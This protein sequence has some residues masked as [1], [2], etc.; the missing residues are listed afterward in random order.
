[1]IARRTTVLL[2]IRS[3]SPR[4][5]SFP[6]VSALPFHAECSSMGGSE[7]RRTRI[8]GLAIPLVA[9][10][11]GLAYDEYLKPRDSR[12][13]RPLLILK[14]TIASVFA[15]ILAGFWYVFWM[16]YNLIVP[17]GPC[18]SPGHLYAIMILHAFNRLFQ[19]GFSSPS[20]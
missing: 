18:F 8:L 20:V 4:S 3:V 9:G 11:G 5:N 15:F 7:T 10:A 19:S 1:M 14:F 13:S 17:E 16:V 2:R 12:I 6:P